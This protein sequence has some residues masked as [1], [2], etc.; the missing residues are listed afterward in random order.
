MRLKSYVIVTD[1][2]ES[3]DASARVLARMQCRDLAHAE[4]KRP[5]LCPDIAGR[6]VSFADWQAEQVVDLGYNCYTRAEWAVAKRL[7]RASGDLF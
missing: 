3:P 1:T 6:L 2:A 7:N 4:L 5:V